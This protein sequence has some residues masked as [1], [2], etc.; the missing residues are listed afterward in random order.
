MTKDESLNFYLRHLNERFGELKGALEQFLRV[1]SEE[2]AKNKSA[3]AETACERADELARAMADGDQPN[4]LR[5]L[6]SAFRT[7]YTSPTS[8]GA[9][10]NVLKQI[11]EV[12]PQIQNHKWS[13]AG[14]AEDAPH[15]FDALFEKCRAE[16]NLNELFDDLIQTLEKILDS[17][18]IDSI[19]AISSIKKL[20][21]TL[22]NNKAGSYLSVMTGWQFTLSVM[23]NFLWEELGR[24]PVLGSLAKAL[25]KTMKEADIELGALHERVAEEMSEQYGASVTVLTFEQ[26][27][28]LLQAPDTK[29]LSDGEND[30]K[31]SN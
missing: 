14:S 6:S 17:G 27:Q 3:L 22:R 4:W 20:I 5:R 13:F 24:V 16:S 7:Y 15:D 1:L 18:Q 28:N 25:E 10:Y 21:A 26:H 11:M 12:Y 23:K 29:Q 8:L 19:R 2:N 31:L 9:Q 30:E